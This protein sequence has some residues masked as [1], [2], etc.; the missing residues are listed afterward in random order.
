MYQNQQ[1]LTKRGRGRPRKNADFDYFE[2]RK[3]ISQNRSKSLLSEGDRERE[4]NFMRCLKRGVGRPKR[5]SLETYT[6]YEKDEALQKPEYYI[7]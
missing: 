7:D 5:D 2:E 3:A 1:A 4:L 6:S